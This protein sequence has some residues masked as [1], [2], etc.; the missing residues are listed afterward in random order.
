V[1][2]VFEQILQLIE[3]GEVRISDHGYEEL[4]AH[5]LFVRE[6]IRSI[7]ESVLIEEYTDYPK[8]PCILVLQKDS[9]EKAIHVVWGIPKG[10]NSPA[11]LVTAYRPDPSRWERDYLMRKK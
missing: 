4:V 2:T 9:T 6:I 10:R 1:V 3:R 5:D 7:K 8:G 11:V